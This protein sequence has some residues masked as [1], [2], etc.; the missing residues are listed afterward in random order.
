M[1]APGVVDSIDEVSDVTPGVVKVFVGL[2]VDFFGRSKSTAISLDARP[3]P[4]CQTSRSGGRAMLQYRHFAHRID[5]GAPFR[6]A[7]FPIKEI[8]RHRRPLQS[9]EL[10]HQGRRVGIARF[11][12]VV[13]AEEGHGR[14]CVRLTR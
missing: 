8:H 12:E 4:R 9:A 7:R 13:E 1:Q 11:T 3:R 5:L 14:S 10:Q 2:A 6:R